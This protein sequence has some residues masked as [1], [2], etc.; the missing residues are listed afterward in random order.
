MSQGS[1]EATETA[2]AFL[3]TSIAVGHT[4][5]EACEALDHGPLRAAAETHVAELAAGDRLVRAKRL[6]AGVAGAIAAARLGAL[7]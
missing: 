1:D 5:K 6:A 3:C 2:R 4:A 7:A